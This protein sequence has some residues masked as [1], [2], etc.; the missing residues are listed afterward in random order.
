VGRDLRF[1]WCPIWTPKAA[2]SGGLAPT[3]GRSPDVKFDTS[4]ALDDKVADPSKRGLTL[5]GTD[6]N[7]CL[8]AHV[9]H[10]A[11]VVGQRTGLNHRRSDRRPCARSRPLARV[12]LVGVDHQREIRP[13]GIRHP[14]ALRV[15]L[16]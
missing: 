13:G 8:I 16:G 9:A 7:A 3:V 1:S 12:A 10:P 11:S 5:A 6:R 2:Q 14:H 15:D 4:M